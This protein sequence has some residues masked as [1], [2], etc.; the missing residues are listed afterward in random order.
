VAV[1]AALAALPEQQRRAVVLHYIADLSVPEV[2]EREGVP[3]GTVKSWLHRA[4]IR[5]AAELE[6]TDDSV[7]GGR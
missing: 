2:A 4:R 5:L 3:E 1:I 6:T 7:G